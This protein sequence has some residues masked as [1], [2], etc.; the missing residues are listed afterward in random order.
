MVMALFLVTFTGCYSDFDPACGC[1]EGDPGYGSQT[2]GGDQTGNSWETSSLWFLCYYPEDNT[3]LVVE[4]GYGNTLTVDVAY[5]SLS[6]LQLTYNNT[7]DDCISV[8][9]TCNEGYGE[10]SGEYYSEC[11]ITGF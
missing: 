5:G 4:D 9:V 2:G 6:S 8:Y 7:P 11:D 3:N 10:I 1:W